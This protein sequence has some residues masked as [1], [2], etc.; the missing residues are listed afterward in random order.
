MSRF[1]KQLSALFVAGAAVLATAG[2]ADA[3]F[4]FR[5]SP[6]QFSQFPFGRVVMP[7]GFGVMPAYGLGINSAGAFFP[8]P[9]G[10]YGFVSSRLTYR[11][12]SYP[13]YPAYPVTTGYGSSRYAQDQYNLY[14]AQRAAR[15]GFDGR[16][17]AAGY[18]GR[19]VRAVKPEQ[20]KDAPE[21]LRQAVLAPSDADIASGK[22]LNELL[23]A[24][25]NQESKG[26][27]TEMPFLPPDV[28]AKVTFAGGPAA[29]ALNLVR[30]GTVEFPAALRGSD[31]DAPRRAIET[32]LAAIAAQVRDGKKIPPHLADAV[33]ANVR[34]L[35]AKTVLLADADAAEFLDRMERLAKF[36]KSPEGSAAIVPTWQ[37]VGVSLSDLGRYFERYKIRFGPAAAGNEPAYAALHRG[38][39]G[40]LSQ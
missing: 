36:L 39:V 17:L 34:K 1:T 31:F 35:N 18:N 22:A 28:L 10:G 27:K 19:V 13:L 9:R 8:S 12:M 29:D 24:V 40:Y 15:Y 23:A 20:W 38:M 5:Q 3:Q 37:T 4:F 30:T 2:P 16:V 11:P 26:V 7:F 6:T 32:D 33:A 14:Y 25:R 21:A